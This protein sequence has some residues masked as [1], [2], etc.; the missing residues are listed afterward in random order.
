MMKCSLFM[1]GHAPGG[2]LA[3]KFNF[4]EQLLAFWEERKKPNLPSWSYFSTDYPVRGVWIR[5]SYTH[6]ALGYHW[7]S[8]G[9]F[10]ELDPIPQFIPVRL[11]TSAPQGLLT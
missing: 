8:Q 10:R 9:S 2:Q 11:V 6:I 5:S 1:A 4:L 3:G 7:A